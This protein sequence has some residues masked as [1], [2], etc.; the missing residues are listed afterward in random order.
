MAS[1]LQIVIEVVTTIMEETAIGIICP[2]DESSKFLQSICNKLHG[3][4]FQKTV[5]L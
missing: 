5:V 1:I 4:T 2:E 3:I